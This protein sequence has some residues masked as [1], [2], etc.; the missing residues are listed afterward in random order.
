[1]EIFSDKCYIITPFIRKRRM[2]NK[3]I[4]SERGKVWALNIQYLYGVKK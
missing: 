1:M 4:P 3:K 2:W